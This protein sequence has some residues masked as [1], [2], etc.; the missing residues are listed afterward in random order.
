MIYDVNMYTF[1]NTMSRHRCWVAMMESGSMGLVVQLL[2]LKAL[3]HPQMPRGDQAAPLAITDVLLVEAPNGSP[4]VVDA[5]IKLP[6][7]TAAES[8]SKH[9]SRSGSECSCTSSQQEA[10]SDFT[11][12]TPTLSPSSI[13]P[14]IQNK[15]FTHH[16]LKERCV[17]NEQLT[18]Y[19]KCM[20]NRISLLTYHTTDA[21]RSDSQHCKRDFLKLIRN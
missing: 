3:E 20:G 21:L 5:P 7:G 13:R 12:S 6:T 18:P 4:V 16:A 9:K 2:L 8:R 17:L 15:G 1:D 11:C 10:P 19:L 14:Q